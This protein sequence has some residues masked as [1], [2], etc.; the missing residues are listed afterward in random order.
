LVLQNIKDSV[1]LNIPFFHVTADTVSDFNNPENEKRKSRIWVRGLTWGEFAN[2]K[3]CLP[4]LLDDIETLWSRK[5]DWLLGSDTFYDPKGT[6]L[7]FETIVICTVFC[8]DSINV[9]IRNRL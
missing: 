5:I 3:D 2:D 8:Y 1:L 6:S 4:V 7:L 9:I